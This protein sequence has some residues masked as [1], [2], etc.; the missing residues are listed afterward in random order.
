[1]K[2]LTTHIILWRKEYIYILKHNIPNHLMYK[3][4]KVCR[5]GDNIYFMGR[6]VKI[7]QSK[8][9]GWRR[10]IYFIVEV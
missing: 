8:A 9:R 1:M 6:D 5:G 7:Y 4:Q 3:I 10:L 2:V